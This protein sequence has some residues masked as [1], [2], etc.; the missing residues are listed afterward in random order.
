MDVEFRIKWETIPYEIRS[1]VVSSTI[2][3]FDPD[4]LIRFRTELLKFKCTYES[5]TNTAIFE[6]EKYYIL[7]L[8][9]WSS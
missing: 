5:E 1:K 7:F 8:L 2:S 6:S 4:K 9:N 3:L